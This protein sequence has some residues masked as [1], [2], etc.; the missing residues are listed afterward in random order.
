[1]KR[2]S[3]NIGV[4]LVS[5][6]LDS[7]VT[8]CIAQ[9]ECDEV[10]VMHATYGQ[11]TATRERK[12][13]ED[14]CNN[15]G[16]T[17]KQVVD[18]SYL[19]DFGGSS[20]TDPAAEIPSGL[21]GEGIPNTYVPF[22]NANLLAAAVAWAEAIGADAVYIGAVEED[23]SG[24]PDCRRKFIQSFQRV[25]EEGT[26]PQT[27]III[28]VP[29]ISLS[30]DQVVRLGIGFKAPFESSWSCYKNN[31]NIACGSCE[32]CLLRL[33]AFYRVGVDDPL[34]YEKI[35]EKSRKFIES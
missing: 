5:G 7:L 15:L 6:G 1:M 11:R 13:F 32:S 33:R 2:V 16:I 28:R 30:K 27:G 35:S 8:L 10:A 14:I 20:L 19:A 22:R 3:A 17:R 24:Y 4:V 18:L 34:Q 31:G 23:S 25:I 12:A 21:P 26:L 29:L 9:K